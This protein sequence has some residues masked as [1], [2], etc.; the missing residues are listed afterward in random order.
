MSLKLTEGCEV[1]GVHHLPNKRAKR[2]VERRKTKMNWKYVG[3][4]VSALGIAI[5][6]AV[7]NWY[8]YFPFCT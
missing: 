3:L 1:R 8:W 2:R 5:G 6:I 7:A 4:K